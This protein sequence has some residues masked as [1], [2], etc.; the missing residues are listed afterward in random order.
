MQRC[1]AAALRGA[2]LQLAAGS[3]LIQLHRLLHRPRLS[4]VG[5]RAADLPGHVARVY[6]DK[7]DWQRACGNRPVPEGHGDPHH[8]RTRGC[9]HHGGTV[10]ICSSQIG[11]ADVLTVD[12][13]S[14]Y[15]VKRRYAPIT[16]SW[17]RSQIPDLFCERNNCS[18][19]LDNSSARSTDVLSVVGGSQDSSKPLST[20]PAVRGGTI[21]SKASW[22]DRA[23]RG[24]H[25]VLHCLTRI[26]GQG[27][28]CSAH[29]S[30]I[31]TESTQQAALDEVVDSLPRIIRFPLQ[32][33]ERGRSHLHGKADLVH[34]LR[35]LLHH[36]M[37][38]I[39]IRNVGSRKDAFVWVRTRRMR[40]RATAGADRRSI[41]R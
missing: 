1:Q 15:N 34:R 7:V 35:K 23:C 36:G 6:V 14:R 39:N 40:S 25:H 27:R 30:R 16:G 38:D 4:K 19:V 10:R 5:S 9:L 41:L 24:E 37:Q 18:V 11:A 32:P 26:G 8:C 17:L 28:Q 33:R 3:K 2:L 29:H 22:E 13:Q 12:S 31:G 20:R 21:C